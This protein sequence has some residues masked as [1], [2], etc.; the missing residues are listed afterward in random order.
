[1]WI[2]IAGFYG[3]YGRPE[4]RAK[5]SHMGLPTGKTGHSC[6]QRPDS[7]PYFPQFVKANFMKIL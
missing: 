1:M 7:V 4:L 2:V 6:R 5:K 3:A